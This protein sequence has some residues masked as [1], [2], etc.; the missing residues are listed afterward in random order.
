MMQLTVSQL[1]QM[2]DQTL[3]TPYASREELRK[4]CLEA[5]RYGFKTV[6]INN[7]PIP[8]CKEILRGSVVLCDAAVSFPLGQCTVETKVF[9]TIDVIAKG[10][11]EVD[12]VVN[13]GEVKNG[14]WVFVA[15]EMRRIVAAC[16]ERGVISKVIFEN[17]YLTDDEK[18]RLCDVAL[19]EKPDF[20]KTSTGFGTPPAGVTVGATVADVRLMKACVG[21]SLRI[22]AAGGVRTIEDA[23]A[24]I[25]AGASRIGTSRGVAILAGYQAMLDKG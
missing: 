18:K 3:L 15:D 2:I 5:M 8:Y 9:E 16:R 6:A 17:C 19:A 23:L 21:D 22:K 14:N 13:L 20:I 4:H 10:A 25:E 7:A 1:A 11:D 24:M 12:Y